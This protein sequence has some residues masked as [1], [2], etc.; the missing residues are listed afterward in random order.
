MAEDLGDRILICKDCHRKFIF[1]VNEQKSFGYKG[2]GDPV[3]CRY[4]RRQKR[5]LDL[6][7]N[8]GGKISEEIRHLAVCDKCGRAFYTKIERMEGVNLYCDDCW[9]EI[10]YAKNRK[11]SRGVDSEQTASH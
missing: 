8:D 10:K 1:T 2:W 11:E 4:C 7:L 5:I 3:R 9:A 6:V